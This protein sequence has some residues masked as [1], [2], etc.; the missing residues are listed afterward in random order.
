MMF[1]FFLLVIALGSLL[2][3]AFKLTLEGDKEEKKKQLHYLENIANLETEIKKIQEEFTKEKEERK[4]IESLLEK[5]KSES[6]SLKS[7]NSQL[8]QKAADLDAVRDAMLKKD[9]EIKKE[10]AEK[11]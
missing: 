5:T 8:T 9:D 6:D 10:V 7:A 1:L 11:E 3:L 4:K 2:F